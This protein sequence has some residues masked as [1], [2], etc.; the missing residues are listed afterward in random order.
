MLPAVA[1]GAATNAIRF[2]VF[3]A[4][5]RALQRDETRDA[6]L[7]PA[8]AV[9]AGGVAGAVSAVATQPIDVV[10]AN[11]MGLEADRFASTAGCTRALVAAGGIGALFQGLTP[12]VVRVFIEVGLQ[13]ALYEQISPMLDRVLG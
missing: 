11:M 8:Q 9:L 4:I 3:G 1:K 6:P 7:P 5:K 2:P 10:K 13:F 12:R